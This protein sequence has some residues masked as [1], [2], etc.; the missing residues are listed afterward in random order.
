[1]FGKKTNT[2]LTVIAQGTKVSGETHFSGQ[3]LIGGELKGKISAADKLTIELDGYV[4]G[5]LH[6]KLLKVSGCFKGKL[7]CQKLTITGSGVVEGEIACDSMEIFEGGQF[8]GVRVKEDIALLSS[9]LT[10]NH[11]EAPQQ[12]LSYTEDQ[13]T[14]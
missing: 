12:E 9:E 3:A 11:N 2:E 14:A 7:K 5:E 13:A 8:I 4:E 1:M 6:C 10:D